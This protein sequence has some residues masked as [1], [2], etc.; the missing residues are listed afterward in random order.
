MPSTSTLLRICPRCG[1]LFTTKT[2]YAKLRTTQY[3]SY[4]CVYPPW[5]ERFWHNIAKC[6]H[7]PYCLYCCWL[8][9][10][11]INS[12]GYGMF[13]KNNRIHMAHRLSWEIHNNATLPRRVLH[14]VVQHLCHTTLC[15]NPWHL[16]YSSQKENVYESIIIGRR[17]HKLSSAQVQEIRALRQ[18][19]VSVIALAQQFQVGRASIY[20]I[21][22]RKAWRHVP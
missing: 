16:T 6:S 11:T 13:S 5:L 20:S 14:H 7:T 17:W 1:T 10:G 22:N 12:Y 15:C 8:W 3:C 2:Y 21:I 18:Q 4:A 19:G 9:H